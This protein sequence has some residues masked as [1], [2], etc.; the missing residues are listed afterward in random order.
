MSDTDRELLKALAELAQATGAMQAQMAIATI[1]R[2]DDANDIKLRAVKALTRGARS[3][4]A[5][6]TAIVD[7]MASEIADLNDV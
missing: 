4:A 2:S 1:L 3:Y 7:Q 6:L 5:G